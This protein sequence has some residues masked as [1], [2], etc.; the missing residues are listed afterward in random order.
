[1][2]TSKYAPAGC[3][4]QARSDGMATLGA[5]GSHAC[6][7][8]EP[9]SLSETDQQALF[10]KATNEGWAIIRGDEEGPAITSNLLVRL[11]GADSS[12]T[13]GYAPTDEVGGVPCYFDDDPD[14]SAWSDV[15][16][17][18]YVASGASIGAGAPQGVNCSLEEV[19]DDRCR[20]ELEQY[21]E[22]TGGSYTVDS[23]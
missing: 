7:R 10:D 20:L 11:K 1:M 19:L 21:I 16:G 22:S 15:S 14:A 18:E 6:R 8:W 3:E 4:S 5:R 17:D 12:Y 2:G 9:R 23:L 13:G